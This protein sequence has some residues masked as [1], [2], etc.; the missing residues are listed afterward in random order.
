MALLAP[1]AP[2]RDW[3]MR[4]RHGVLAASLVPR[5]NLK[6]GCLR[7]LL[8]SIQGRLD[9]STLGSWRMRKGNVHVD[10]DVVLTVHSASKAQAVI[11]SSLS[12][13][14]Q[15]LAPWCLP[16]VWAVRIV[17]T[18]HLGMG[19]LPPRMQAFQRPG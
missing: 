16:Q 6:R 4:V 19:G 15:V 17:C 7:A 11:S 5:S 18:L 12:G 9:L 2:V 14:C 1:V 13:G 10:K 8:P 3:R